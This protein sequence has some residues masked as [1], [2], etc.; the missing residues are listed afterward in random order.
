MMGGLKKFLLGGAT[1]FSPS[2]F[3]IVSIICVGGGILFLIRGLLAL[4]LI[5]LPF[6]LWAGYQTLRRMRN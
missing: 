2:Y 3:F 6:G 4:G 1:E 5:V